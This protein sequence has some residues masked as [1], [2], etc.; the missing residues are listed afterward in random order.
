MNSQRNYRAIASSQIQ[1]MLCMAE[2]VLVG[3][4]DKLLGNSPLLEF[5]CSHR[6]ARRSRVA[7]ERIATPETSKPNAR[8]RRFGHGWLFACFGSARCTRERQAWRSAISNGR[9]AVPSAMHGRQH[10]HCSLAIRAS[11]MRMPRHHRNPRP[12]RSVNLT[13]SGRRRLAAPG[14]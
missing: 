4:H 8:R 5:T 6:K 14:R 7:V 12:N 10:R 2:L 13:R 11:S 1:C 9:L 3:P